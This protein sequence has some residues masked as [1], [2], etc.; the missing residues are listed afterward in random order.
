MSYEVCACGALDDAAFG[1]HLIEPHHLMAH[2]S[3]LK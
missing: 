2:S 1:R 3:N